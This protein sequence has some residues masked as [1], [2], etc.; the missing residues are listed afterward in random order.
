MREYHG[1]CQGKLV[2]LADTLHAPSY[3]RGLPPIAHLQRPQKKGQAGG[4]NSDCPV[5]LP[6]PGVDVRG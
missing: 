3:R 4:F 1:V 5:P 2:E 6:S